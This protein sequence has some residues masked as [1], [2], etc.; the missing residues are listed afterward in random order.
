MSEQQKEIPKSCLPSTRTGEI[1]PWR[2][3]LISFNAAIWF[4]SNN[5]WL[6]SFVF[7]RNIW[8]NNWTSKINNAPTSFELKI[9]DLVGYVYTY[10][11][12]IQFLL[13]SESIISNFDFLNLFPCYIYD[14]TWKNCRARYDRTDRFSIGGKNKRNLT[15]R[16]DGTGCSNSSE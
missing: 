5:R 1:R 14:Y 2:V 16:L 12:G 11:S 10:L 15:I 13:L 6:Y 7:P 3:P 4:C 9:S 8:K